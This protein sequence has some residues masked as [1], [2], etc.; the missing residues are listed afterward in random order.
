MILKASIVQGQLYH[1][2][3]LNV[4]FSDEGHKQ[5]EDHTIDVTNTQVNVEEEVYEN[6]HDS[7]KRQI[8]YKNEYPMVR[9]HKKTDSEQCVPLQLKQFE[10]YQESIGMDLDTYKHMAKQYQ[11]W[12]QKLGYFE[13]GKFLL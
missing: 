7:W 10:V 2:L 5:N 8:I 13:H 3:I 6:P 1:S 4:C 12:N 11:Y 9:E